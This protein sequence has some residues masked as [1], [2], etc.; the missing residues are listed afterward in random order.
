MYTASALCGSA[1]SIPFFDKSVR[2]GVD[3]NGLSRREYNIHVI[4]SLV[5]PI[6]QIL[7]TYFAASTFF[8]GNF[9][10]TKACPILAWYSKAEAHYRQN[11]IF[12]HWG[13]GNDF[14]NTFLSAMYT[15]AYWTIGGPAGT[16]L[17]LVSAATALVHANKVASYFGVS[18]L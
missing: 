14:H 17:S 4:K 8:G 11:P 6:F 5:Y 3:V 10:I 15:S 9:L 1:L 2:E 13:L 7:P 16:A 18:V 12:E